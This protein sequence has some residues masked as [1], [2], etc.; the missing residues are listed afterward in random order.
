MIEK[1]VYK[2]KEEFF[3]TLN[4]PKYQWDKRKKDLLD[5]LENFY[6][7]KLHEDKIITIE[8]TEVYG[9]YEPMP[10]K[11]NV[12]ME[13]K[14]KDY[15]K[16]TIASLGTVFKPNSKI[17]VAE[18]AIDEFGYEKYHHTS[19]EAVAKRFVKPAFDKYGESDGVHKW[20]WYQT[21][22]PLDEDTLADWRRIMREEHIS[23]LEAANAFYR[24]EQGEDVSKEKEYFKKARKRFSDKYHDCVVLVESWKVNM[25]VVNNQNNY[26]EIIELLNE[27]RK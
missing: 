9:E 7:Y 17:K 10:R 21:Y 11:V 24:Q 6:D 23:E 13:E 15:E 19:K 2:L 4:I 26:E 14:I 22:K 5:W 3:K 25:G 27:K 16:F 8:I 20:V 18:K 12:S 1:G